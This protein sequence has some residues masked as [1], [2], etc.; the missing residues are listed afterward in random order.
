M[1]KDDF[2]RLL[3][4]YL[5]NGATEKEERFLFSYYNLFQNEPEVLDLLNDDRKEKLKNQIYSG[6]RQNIAKKEHAAP[7][8]ITSM[9]L[10]PLRIAAAAVAIM[11]L[12]LA[13][14]YFTGDTNIKQEVVSFTNH[15][16]ENRIIRLADG[17]TVVLGPA[18]KI[19]YPM[20]FDGL[21]TRE[22]YLEGQ[23]FFD[24]RR[25]S[26][27]PFIVHTGQLQTR[28][29][30]TA[31]NIKAFSNESD[32]TV[33]VKRGKVQVEEKG[34]TL[35]IITPEEQIIYNKNEEKSIRKTVN[36]D[37]CLNWKEHDLFFDNLTFGEAAELLEDR[38]KVKISFIDQSIQ[39]KNFTTTFP[40]N[41]S[42]DVT[43]KS[44][45]EF[46]GAVYEYN[47]EKSIITIRDINKP[48]KN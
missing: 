9:P 41:Q 47:S 27:R 46:N 26:L 12:T 30:G 43:L 8:R 11:A 38:F 2:M 21:S 37:L 6:I 45:C 33:T 40:G 48:S 25:D 1:D 42:L 17:S 5:D 34:T 44:I 7:G 16:K 29:L 14:V 28:V 39:S 4:K 3:R 10:L 32:I 20:S 24:I 35:G 22:V 19:D 13:F 15:L 31:F 18:T 36:V 23:A